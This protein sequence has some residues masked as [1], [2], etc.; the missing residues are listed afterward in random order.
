MSNSEQILTHP[1][2]TRR[3]ALEVGSIGLLGLGMNHFNALRAEAS[4]EERKIQT[5]K[6]CIFIF[7]SGGL[8][9][10]ES[11]DL[12][13]EA[14]EGIRGEFQPISTNTPGIEICE[15]LPLLA[16]RSHLWSICRSLTHAH[17]EHSQ[18]HHVMLTGRS[19]MPRGFNPTKPQRTDHPSIASMLGDVIQSRGPL[20]PAIVLPEKLVH[21]TGRVIPGQFGGQMGSHR[22]PWFIEASPPHRSSYGAYPE[23]NFDPQRRGHKDTRIFQTPNFKIPRGLTHAR[24]NN[25]LQL[26]EQL[27]KQSR[28][29]DLSAEVENYDRYRN[30]AISLLDDK[31]V[32]HALDVVHADEK[33]QERYGKNALAGHC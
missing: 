16:Q 33:T 8:S 1:K 7:L 20:P 11:F 10:H 4:S 22:D 23:Y 29:M 15:H 18:G 17:S 5:S 19:D 32:H 6:S 24:V 12:K 9:Q 28:L 21:S 30:A 13:P 2:M 25:R 3:V 26:L 27:R 14:P 31:K